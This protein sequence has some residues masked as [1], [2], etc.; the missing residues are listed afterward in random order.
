MFT[1]LQFDKQNNN[2]KI[3]NA[4]DYNIILILSKI[5]YYSLMLNHP[6]KTDA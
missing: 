3:K 6:K 5:N 1:K 4:R 2:Q